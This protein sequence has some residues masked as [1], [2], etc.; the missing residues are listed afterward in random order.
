MKEKFGTPEGIRD[1][2]IETRLRCFAERNEPEDHTFVFATSRFLATEDTDSI[3][4]AER[5]TDAGRLEWCNDDSH[6][7]RFQE[8]GY[9]TNASDSKSYL[10][11]VMGKYKAKT[12]KFGCVL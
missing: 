7:G 8:M 6:H 5:V 3:F 4:I 1:V 2:T 10:R 9:V 11:N 12:I